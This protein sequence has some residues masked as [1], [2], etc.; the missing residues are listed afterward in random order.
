MLAGIIIFQN[1]IDRFHCK[2][3]KL[4][5]ADKFFQKRKN[6]QDQVFEIFL[7]LIWKYW[8]ARVQN[9]KE[10]YIYRQNRILKKVTEQL[11]LCTGRV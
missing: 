7:S 8:L 9:F 6:S 10:T 5:I 1:Y 11:H 3:L 2:K 4:D